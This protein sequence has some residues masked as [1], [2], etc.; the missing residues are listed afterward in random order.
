MSTVDTVTTTSSVLKRKIEEVDPELD[1]ESEELISSN[2]RSRDT[3][4]PVSVTTIN[5]PFKFITSTYISEV[6]E[7]IV[8]NDSEPI[9][10]GVD[11]AGRGPVLG[12][13]VY[14][15]AYALESFLDGLQRK[16]G[17][18]DSKVLTESKREELFRLIEESSDNEKGLSKVIGWATTSMT[19]RDISSG[20]LQ[21]SGKGAYNLN[22]QA[23]DVTINL[24][25]QV[26][27]KGVKISK[28]FVDTVGPPATY[29]AKLKGIFPDIEI[30]VAKKADS[31]Y[32][33]VSAA[34][35]VAK[36][37]RDKNIAYYNNNLDILKG[38]KLGSGYP[39]DPNTKTWLNSN[40]DS[41][42]GWC[43]GF[44]RF[45]WATAKDALI[46][47]GAATV[48]YA[49]DVKKDSGY[50]DV[51]SMIANR[52]G[53]ESRLSKKYFNSDNIDLI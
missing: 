21:S 34:S 31:I 52:K 18:A 3:W 14:G 2:K 46:N 36:V 49:D 7:S 13:M 47:N 10:L 39:S 42:F 17:F 9:V 16:Y 51:S 5:D 32:P 30:T 48:V 37:T 24:I 4:V 41:I 22:S 11:E 50:K 40:V 26:L 29:Q 53:D 8:A 25:K 23:H 1:E 44:A 43:F 38:H 27:K 19:A 6:P 45:S 33:I 35:V 12:P 20:M 28:I 15:V